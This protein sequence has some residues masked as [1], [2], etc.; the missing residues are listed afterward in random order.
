MVFAVE[1]S[2]FNIVLTFAE[3]NSHDN[4]WLKQSKFGPDLFFNPKPS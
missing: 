1:E 4:E 3:G 2:Y